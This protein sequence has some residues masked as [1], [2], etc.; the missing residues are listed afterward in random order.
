MLSTREQVL[1]EL[2]APVIEA[3]QC[4]LWGVDFSS[5]GR[6]SL[7]RVYIDKSDGVNLEDCEKVSRQISSL[8]DVEDPVAG[9]YVLE[10]SSPGMSRTLYKPSQYQR[11]IGELISVRLIRAFDGRKKFN[12]RLIDIKNNEVIVQVEDEE[13]TLPL[14]WIDRARLVPE[15]QRD[16]EKR[17][18]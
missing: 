5:E 2:F 8:L 13:F 11:Y 14:E 16:V 12:G 18:V 1:S 15:F 9:H 7:L 4:E 3:L 10:V 6:H 17:I